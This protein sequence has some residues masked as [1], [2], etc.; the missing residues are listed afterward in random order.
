MGSGWKHLRGPISVHGADG[1]DGELSLKLSRLVFNRLRLTINGPQCLKLVS[2]LSFGGNNSA[3][4]PVVYRSGLL[5]FGTR[6]LS[7][8]GLIGGTREI[9]VLR[10]HCKCR[11][12]SPWIFVKR[13]RKIVERLV[14]VVIM[15]DNTLVESHHHLVMH[16]S[17]VVTTSTLFVW[18]WT[19]SVAVWTLH[20][21]WV[22]HRI[23]VEAMRRHGIP[24]HDD[25]RRTCIHWVSVLP[26]SLWRM[27]P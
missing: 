17:R 7:A 5:D 11:V 24:R 15:D 10:L 8:S 27:M 18:A 9:E 13:V 20:R 16:L 21:A 2:V 26:C 4:G 19:H 22:A 25:R 23:R 12:R 14:P 1:R 6:D 3:R